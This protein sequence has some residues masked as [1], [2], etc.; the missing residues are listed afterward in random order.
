MLG[1][2]FML[3]VNLKKTMMSKYFKIPNKT[4]A[5]SVFIHVL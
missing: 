2:I 5:L 1:Y 3:K 4:L